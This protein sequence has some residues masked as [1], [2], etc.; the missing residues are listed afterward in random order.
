MKNLMFRVAVAVVGIPII[1][2]TVMD[3]G[4]PFFLLTSIII[5]IALWEFYGLT[6]KKLV[7]PNKWGGLLAAWVIS[8]LIFFD[9]VSRLSAG[10]FLV[11]FGFLMITEIWFNR[12]N[13]ILNLAVTLLG[14]VYVGI[15]FSSV[16][17][18]RIDYG[19]PVVLYLLAVVWICDTFSYFFGTAFGR[20]KLFPRISPNKSYEGAVAG[21][22]GALG[23]A[24]VAHRTF[25]DSYTILDTVVLACIGGGLG[26]LG[27]LLE[28]LMKR[29]AGVK[30]SSHLLPGHGGL[31]DRF[32]SLLIT[33]PLSYAYL[34]FI[35][36]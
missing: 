5:V 12:P 15:F 23:V 33:F 8:S 3:G 35:Q 9:G 18:L 1:L 21:L 25:F 16:L 17:L 7:Y 24:Y 22:L 27:D 14:I 20:H 4:W 6:E 28:S 34:L 32:D 36:T 11:I 26:Q 30:D 10:T 2:F 13:P 19:W 31:L 29:D